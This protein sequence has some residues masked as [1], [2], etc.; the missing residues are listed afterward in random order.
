MSLPQ[1]QSEIP[2]EIGDIEVRL[3]DYQNGPQ[4]EAGYEVQV[5]DQNGNVMKVLKGNLVPHLTSGQISGLA[6]FMVQLRTKAEQE[7]LS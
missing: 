6:G 4:D 1:A 2:T 7:I 3:T 5:I